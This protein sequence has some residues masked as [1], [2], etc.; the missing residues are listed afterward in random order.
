MSQFCISCGEENQNEA[1]FCRSCGKKLIKQEYD[2]F[3]KEIKLNP[4]S[5]FSF[6][7]CISRQTYWAVSIASIGVPLILGIVF[8]IILPKL[9]PTLDISS[10]KESFNQELVLIIII[11]F[12]ILYVWIPLATSIKRFRDANFSPWLVLLNIIPYLG[13]LIVLVLNGF[14]PS[15]EQGNKYCKSKNNL[16]RK[17]TRWIYIAFLSPI[18][19]LLIAIAIL[20]LMPMNAQE[21]ILYTPTIKQKVATDTTIKQAKKIDNT[22]DDTA[23]G[24]TWKD[25]KNDQSKPI[26]YYKNWKYKEWE[27]KTIDN[28]VLYSTHG[29]YTWGDTFGFIN[30]KGSCENN[31]LNFYVSTFNKLP[32]KYID[33]TIQFNITI[34]EAI[35]KIDIPIVYS[36]HAFGKIDI[37][38]FS[39]F[40]V[41]KKFIELL[42][43]GSLISISMVG[44][45]EIIKYFDKKK[46]KYNLN[47][48]TATYLKSYKVCKKAL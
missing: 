25:D 42:R 30:Y 38:A 40:N 37:V 47:G 27:I 3:D 4:F 45:K 23:T 12:T 35:F 28:M 32:K 5:L 43:K 16:S 24:V 36:H 34:D 31:I 46:E 33:K 18:L 20:K 13:S 11:S 21:P 44:P 41:N 9:M 48:F 15:V 2:K 8:A 29:T 1:Q 10:L 7:G 6:S 39:N 14:F 17:A 22:F 19:L 26:N